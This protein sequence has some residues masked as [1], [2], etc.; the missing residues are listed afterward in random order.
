MSGVNM[1][2]V[3]ISSFMIISRGVSRMRW[4][5]ADEILPSE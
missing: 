5:E 4:L 3:L 1:M 2:R